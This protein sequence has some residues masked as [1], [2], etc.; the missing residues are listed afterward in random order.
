MT[1]SADSATQKKK[2]MLKSDPGCAL[3][4]GSGGNKWMEIGFTWV[5]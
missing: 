1:S 2:K 4:A 5:R 3:V